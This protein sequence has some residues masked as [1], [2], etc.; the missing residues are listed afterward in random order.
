M[1]HED[2]LDL[3]DVCSIDGGPP[4]DDV[5]VDEALAIKEGKQ[6]LLVQR[7]LTLALYWTQLPLLDPMLGLL[8][9][10]R[11]VVHLR[12]VHGHD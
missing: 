5:R 10:L 2:I 11:G 12:L 7:A 1:P 4:W 9:R 6:H 8:F 3:H